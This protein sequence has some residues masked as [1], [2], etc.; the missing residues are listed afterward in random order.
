MLCGSRTRYIT[1]EED[2]AGFARWCQDN[3]DELLQL[4]VG[5]HYGEWYGQKIQRTYGLDHKRFAL[6]NVGRWKNFGENGEY[7]NYPDCCEVVPTLYTGQYQGHEHLLGLYDEMKSTVGSWAVN[8]W[9][10]P[11]GLWVYFHEAKHSMK[12]PL[13]K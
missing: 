4:G 10:R 1:P 9:D 8:G 12:M 2:N 3:K 6:F 13:D 5:R 7:K 11:E